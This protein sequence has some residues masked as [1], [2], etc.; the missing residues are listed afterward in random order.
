MKEIPKGLYARFLRAVNSNYAR[1]KNRTF[2]E[3]AI[4]DVIIYF[5][6]H[7]FNGHNFLRVGENN[8]R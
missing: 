4:D 2:A 1:F 6:I 3:I 5:Q 7:E 8:G